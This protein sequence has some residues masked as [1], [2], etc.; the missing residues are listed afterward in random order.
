MKNLIL[1][2]A[3][4]GVITSIQVPSREL[5]S[6]VAAKPAAAKKSPVKTLAGKAVVHGRK[7]I[8]V[9]RKAA[10]TVRLMR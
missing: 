7:V 2:I 5:Q 3:L 10:S 1:L 4:I 6:K 9:F 8:S